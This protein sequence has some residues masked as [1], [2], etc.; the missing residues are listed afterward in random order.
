MMEARSIRRWYLVHKWTSLVC[1]L[2][3][4]LL[5][6]TGLPLI[7]YAELEELL[8]YAAAPPQPV[9]EEARAALDGIAPAA[10]A[11]PPGKGLRFLLRGEHKPVVFASSSAR[12]G[13]PPEEYD[14]FAFD[15][16]T[17][18]QL[19]IPRFDEGIMFFLLRLHTDMFAGLPGML[20]LGFMGLLFF[21]A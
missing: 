1:T 7:F 21:V 18:Q 20:F 10:R 12:P 17:G 16:R 13:A 15:Q 11:L 8:G 5:C 9:A 6:I 3:L 4:L 14:V 2:F 19:D